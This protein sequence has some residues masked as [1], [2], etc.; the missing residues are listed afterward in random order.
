V[1]W[2]DVNGIAKRDFPQAVEKGL[3]LLGGKIE[4]LKAKIDASKTRAAFGIKWIAF[5]EQLRS[6]F[7]HYLEVLTNEGSS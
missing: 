7:G 1:D 3:F 6:V 4:G 5:E 2:D